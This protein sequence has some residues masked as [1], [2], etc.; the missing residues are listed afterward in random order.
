M[1]IDQSCDYD[2]KINYYSIKFRWN[3]TGLF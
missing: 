3:S 1:I 2:K